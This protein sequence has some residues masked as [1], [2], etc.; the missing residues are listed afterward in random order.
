MACDLCGKAG[1]LVRARIEGTLLRVCERCASYG[2]VLR[3]ERVVSPKTTRSAP[4]LVLVEDYAASIRKARG[5]MTQKE[6]A[7]KIQEKESVMNKLESGHMKPSIKLAQ[8]LEKLLKIRLLAQDDT[9]TVTTATRD[10]GPLT[11]GDMI[12]LK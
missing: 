8:K 7:A 3:Q 12:K 1:G 9:P 6:F 5:Q 11:I 4:E 10:T 2:T